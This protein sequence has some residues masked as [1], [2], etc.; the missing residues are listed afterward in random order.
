MTDV[1]LNFE[2]LP[3]EIWD[4]LPADFFDEFSVKGIFHKGKIYI[5]GNEGNCHERMSS[6]FNTEFG[7]FARS[8]PKIGNYR[9][10]VTNGVAEI[11]SGEDRPRQPDAQL[12]RKIIVSDQASFMPTVVVEVMVSHNVPYQELADRYI[13]AST[14]VMVLLVIK[15]F[16]PPGKSAKA[17]PMPGEPTQMLFL[18]YDRINGEPVMRTAIDFGN[19]ELTEER[20][21]NLPVQRISSENNVVTIASELV[22][23]GLQVP[24]G[25][26]PLQLNLDEMRDEYF[27]L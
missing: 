13:T 22:Y 20:K 26:K 5:S 15:V 1:C 24:A 17:E 21:A 12:G 25:A 27:G 19:A 4:E 18:R 11:R 16:L 7:I 23:S 14:S 2:N 9:S 8:C 6:Y 3:C 10:I